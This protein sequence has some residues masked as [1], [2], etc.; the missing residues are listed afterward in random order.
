MSTAGGAEPL[1]EWVF[2]AVGGFLTLGLVI[3]FLVVLLRARREDRGG[4][5]EG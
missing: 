1:Y 2:L 5:D 3:V 4:P